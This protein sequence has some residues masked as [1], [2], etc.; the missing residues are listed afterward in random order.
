MRFENFAFVRFLIWIISRFSDS[1]EV[2]RFQY[3]CCL[4]FAIL[5]SDWTKVF[6]SQHHCTVFKLHCM[7]LEPKAELSTCLLSIKSSVDQQILQFEDKKAIKT[8][9]GKALS[10]SGN[11]VKRSNTASMR[12]R[13]KATKHWFKA[14]N[15]H[16]RTSNLLNSFSSRWKIFEM[17]Q[18]FFAIFFLAVVLRQHEMFFVFDDTSTSRFHF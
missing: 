6:D 17:D 7:V 9:Q 13:P 10:R 8:V 15:F 5:Q 16:W 2:V 18:E 3:S 12:T 4:R 1:F 11:C 14:S